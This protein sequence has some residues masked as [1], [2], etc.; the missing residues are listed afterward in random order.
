MSLGTA[1]QGHGLILHGTCIIDD[2]DSPS[3]LLGTKQTKGPTGEAAQVN[4]F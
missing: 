3:L 1:R 4:A 2:G